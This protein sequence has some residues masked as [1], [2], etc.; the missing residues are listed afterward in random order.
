MAPI[1]GISADVERI[2][3]TVSELHRSI[4]DVTAEA[5]K[6]SGLHRAE[7]VRRAEEAGAALARLEWALDRA[8]AETP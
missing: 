1:H 8:T 7:I 6:L 3:A 5:R 2:R 4:D